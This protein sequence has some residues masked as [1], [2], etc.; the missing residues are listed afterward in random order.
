MKNLSMKIA[1][2]I[3]NEKNDTLIDIYLSKFDNE[4]INLLLIFFINLVK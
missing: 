4:Y 1:E 2:I 3:Y